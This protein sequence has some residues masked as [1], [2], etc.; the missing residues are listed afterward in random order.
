MKVKGVNMED[1]YELLKGYSLNDKNYQGWRREHKKIFGEIFSCAFDE[2]EEA[3]IH[4]TAALINISQRSFEAAMHKLDILESICTNDYDCAVVN[5]FIGLNHELLG[6]ENKMNEYYEKLERSNISFVFPLA[7]HPYYR[8]AKFAQRDS[9]CTKA[10][11]YYQKA[12]S[13]YDGV[14][15]LN[16]KN[17][18]I[19]AQII[20]DVAT[21][22][23]YMHKYDEC[24]KFLAL[25]KS[26]D[27]SENQQIT[28]VRAI[29][30]A[31]QGRINDSRNL[32]DTMSSFLRA[33]C[34]PMIEAI[35]AK[36]DPH[37]C[38]VK[39]DKS[40]Y[41][42]FWNTLIENKADLEKLIN[43]KRNLDAQKNVTEM[44]SATLSFMKRQIACRIEVSDIT[45][46]VYCKNYYVKT[47]IEEYKS[48]F[49]IKPN[50][51]NNWTFISVNEFEKY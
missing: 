40:A 28:Y 25:S 51:L 18:S 31:V 2:N 14:T 46:T 15:D 43:S 21:L 7:F 42:D 29:L 37:Y 13:F 12:L 35:A 24:E 49:S 3:Q 9:E 39:Q 17:R 20:Y 41:T 33:N 47:L 45:I 8:T 19:I 38:V 36:R 23:L 4:L 27:G 1:Y 48:L 6:N 11:F 44:L 32:L 10:I 30:Y 50:E 22:Y 26:Y 34:E 16:S 5:Y